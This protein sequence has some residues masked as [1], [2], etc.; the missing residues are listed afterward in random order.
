VSDGGTVV[1]WRSLSPAALRGVI[2]ELVTREGTEYGAS[3]VPLEDKVAA[4][5]GQLERGEAVVLFDP[6]TETVNV[7]LRRD[8]PAS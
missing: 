2:E 4:V 5:R 1:P 8:L 7:V 3:D 6:R